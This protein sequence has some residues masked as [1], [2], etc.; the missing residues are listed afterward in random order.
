MNFGKYGVLQTESGKP[1]KIK[2][3][4]WLSRVIQHEIDH[5]NGDIFIKKGGEKIKKDD[6]NHGED[7]V[8]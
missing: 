5:L 1:Q 8:D 7:I 6:L 4:G 2:A 3:N